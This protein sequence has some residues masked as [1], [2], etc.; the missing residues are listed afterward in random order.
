MDES[1]DTLKS[2]LYTLSAL[3]TYVEQIQY[4]PNIEMYQSTLF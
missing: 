2:S 1:F 4:A 3:E